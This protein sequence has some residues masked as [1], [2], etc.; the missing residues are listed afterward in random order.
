MKLS[1]ANKLTASY[2]FVVAVTLLFTGAFLSQR[3]KKTF[4]SHLE[5]SL[6]TEA[7]LIEQ[8][9]PSKKEDLQGWIQAE[10]REMG[11]RI[12]VI[13]PDGVVAA[14][15]ERTSDEVKRMDNHAERPEVRAALASG[16]GESTRHSATLDED[17]M[18]V[19]L[20][21][22]QGEGIIRLALPV[23][24]VRH[25]IATFQRDFL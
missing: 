18:Y 1:F 24:D 16:M 2:L 21:R 15:S 9:I 19:A 6:A 12:T 11:C 22:A 10:G 8:I 14:D 20:P 4:L 23:T 17:M 7:K 3:L 25:R 5:Q 13:G